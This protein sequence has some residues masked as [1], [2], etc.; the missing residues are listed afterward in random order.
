MQYVGNCSLHLETYLG[1]RQELLY[2]EDDGVSAIINAELC[3]G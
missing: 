3:P 2:L 1:S